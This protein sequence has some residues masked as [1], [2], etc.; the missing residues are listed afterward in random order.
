MVSVLLWG[1]QSPYRDLAVRES[2]Q[3]I[4]EENQWK[5]GSFCS[6]LC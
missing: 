5:A 4:P 1:P 6:A 2:T 3:R